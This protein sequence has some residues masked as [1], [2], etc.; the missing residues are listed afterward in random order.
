MLRL[1]AFLPANGSR[2]YLY[3]IPVQPILFGCRCFLQIFW[4]IIY[5]II[6][7]DLILC[8]HGFRGPLS[9]LLIRLDLE[10]WIFFHYILQNYRPIQIVGCNPIILRITVRRCYYLGSGV[11]FYGS[12]ARIS[13]DCLRRLGISM[14]ICSPNTLFTLFS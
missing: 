7:D 2:N 5:L 12:A 3:S 8:F 6:D 13:G 1:Y 9:S 10:V 4:G 11:R 14:W